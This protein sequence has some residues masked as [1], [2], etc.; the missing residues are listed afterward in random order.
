M[1]HQVITAVRRHGFHLTAGV[2]ALLTAC[3]GDEPSAPPAPGAIAITATTQ[4]ADILLFTYGIAIDGGT[5][6]ATSSSEHAAFQVNGLSAGPHTVSLTDLPAS[7]TSGT[8]TR[9]T[10][11]RGGDTAQLVFAVHCSPT[12]GNIS[13]NI[14]TSGAERDPD[15]YTV[16]VD[17]TARGPLQPTGTMAVT[18]LDP[19]SHSVSVQGIESNCTMAGAATRT[20]TVTAGATTVL[21][22][23]I[24]C[25]ATRGTIR[26]VASTT[27][28]DIDGD[29]FTL[30]NNQ[31]YVTR[32]AVNGT[33]TITQ[34][35]A[36]SHTI[37]IGDVDG[38]CSVSGGATR[39]ITLVAGDTVVV[40][41]QVSCE[42]I[43]YGTTAFTAADPASDTLPAAAG[44]GPRALDVVSIS[45][46]YA[47]GFLMLTIRFTG[48][49]SASRSAA[50][51]LNGFLDFDV[52]ENAQT[53]YGAGINS[54]GGASTQGVDYVLSFF[55]MSLASAILYAYDG[56]AV[57]VPVSFGG[58][59]V[60]VR[61]PYSMM[62][63]DDGNMTISGVFGTADR[64]TDLVPNT[65]QIVAHRSGA[66]LRATRTDDA[67]RRLLPP[68]GSVLAPWPAIPWRK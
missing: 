5:P 13:V 4:I 20:L 63:D 43:V 30:T 34:L 66:A 50:N 1:R 22:A 15:G 42:A 23:T 53:G 21:D 7:C 36:G 32:I 28:S 56:S 9:T 35:F 67:I 8:D 26:V 60:M 47:P 54:F 49:V 24:S 59:S 6:R 52:D 11:L 40:N 17:G 27:G 33:V 16:Y 29:G 39:Q 14:V 31:V 61:I 58:D 44:T 57:L 3:S 65:G 45:G 19:G 46:R 55:E 38:N 2:I 51:A 41:V 12:L 10:T 68:R 48:P 25:I 62:G 37:V 64:P 18:R